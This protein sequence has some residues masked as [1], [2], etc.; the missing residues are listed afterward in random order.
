MQIKICIWEIKKNILMF[1]LLACLVVSFVS[2]AFVFLEMIHEHICLKWS[3]LHIPALIYQL[4]VEILIVG[5]ISQPND[6]S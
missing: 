1:C 5:L 2:Y 4:L 3:K 6:I